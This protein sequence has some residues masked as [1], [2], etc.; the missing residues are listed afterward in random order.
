MNTV[1][2]GSYD[3]NLINT[4]GSSSTKW[5]MGVGNRNTSRDDTPSPGYYET[6]RSLSM[7]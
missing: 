6:N 7:T 1:G 3:T 2:P 4:I 5:S